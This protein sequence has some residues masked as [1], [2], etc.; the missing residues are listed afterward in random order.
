MSPSID[1]EPTAP[2]AAP[3]RVRICLISIGFA[4]QSV[5]WTTLLDVPVRQKVF[6]RDAA[7]R[8]EAGVSTFV[9]SFKTAFTISP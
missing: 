7:F 8:R 4:L 2:G 3:G 1:Y 6:G 5:H 9:R